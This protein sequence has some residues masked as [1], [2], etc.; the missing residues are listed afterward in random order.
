MQTIHLEP[1]QVPAILRANYSGKKFKAQVCESVSI[2]SDAGLWCGGSRDSYSAIELA[3]GN[4]LPLPGQE[5]SPW[6]AARREHIVTLKP[7]FAIVRHTTFS[8]KDMG[9]TFYLHPDNAAAMLPPPSQLSAHETIVLTATR[10]YKSSYN[11]QDRYDI[12]KPYGR[13]ALALYPSREQWEI[14]KA[15]LIAAGFLNK[16]GAITVKGRNAI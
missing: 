2:P 5:S 6:N 11:G 1:A 13:D 15:K 10:Q 14:A 4:Q 16:A 7:G 9:L 12:A 8:G 3:S